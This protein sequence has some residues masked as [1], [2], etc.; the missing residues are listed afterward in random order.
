MRLNM[1]R[2]RVFAVLGRRGLRR[3]AS[4][5]LS[6]DCLPVPLYL[7]PPDTVHGCDRSGRHREVVRTQDPRILHQQNILSRS[8]KPG[9]AFAFV[10]PVV[11]Y[12]TARDAVPRMSVPKGAASAAP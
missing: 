3:I 2:S 9:F 7:L 6:S 10:L 12:R 5:Q 8:I 1:A 4:L 11:S